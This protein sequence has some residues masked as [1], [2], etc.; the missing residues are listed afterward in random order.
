MKLLIENKEIE[1]GSTVSCEVKVNCH[2]GERNVHVNISLDVLKN[3]IN[4]KA[5]QL[6]KSRGFKSI[7]IIETKIC[8]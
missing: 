5:K 1:L 7:E 8:L 6:L 3:Q 4:E 2:T